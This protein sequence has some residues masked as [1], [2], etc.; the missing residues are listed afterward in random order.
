MRQHCVRVAFLL[1]QTDFHKANW[2]AEKEKN[3]THQRTYKDGSPLRERIGWTCFFFC[4]GHLMLVRIPS[5]L[6]QPEGIQ[7]LQDSVSCD[8]GN[9]LGPLLLQTAEL[10]RGMADL[11]THLPELASRENQHAP[12]LRFSTWLGC[13]QSV[14]LLRH[15][16]R[17]LHLPVLQRWGFVI[18]LHGLLIH[19]WLGTQR[20]KIKTGRFSQQYVLKAGLNVIVGNHGLIHLLGKIVL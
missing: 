8:G 19:L 7:W 2:H 12:G 4:L 10:R 16:V 6:T 5:S 15:P 17:V 14:C 18:F 20:S 3:Q 13:S 11:S 1:M 9:S